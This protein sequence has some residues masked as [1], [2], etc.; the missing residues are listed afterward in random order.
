[1]ATLRSR[2][3][4][5]GGAGSQLEVLSDVVDKLH[6]LQAVVILP[7]GV[8]A[9]VLEHAPD[10]DLGAVLVGARDEAGMGADARGRRRC[11]CRAG[12]AISRGRICSRGRHGSCICKEPQGGSS[13]SIAERGERRGSIEGDAA[14]EASHCLSE[15]PGDGPRRWAVETVARYG[16]ISDM[17]G[18]GSSGQRGVC[19]TGNASAADALVVVGVVKPTVMMVTAARFG[20]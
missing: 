15:A 3:G 20:G 9:V 16:L 13:I 8:A 17:N 18:N 19:G 1:M 4:G 11:R 2:T 6:A 5:G 12:V 10:L 14:G 7:R